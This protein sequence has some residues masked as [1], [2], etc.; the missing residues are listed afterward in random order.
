M[1]DATA[2]LIGAPGAV[3]NIV[4]EVVG[5]FD[6]LAKLET[7]INQLSLAGIDRGMM[8]VLGTKAQKTD[9]PGERENEAA[10]R[11]ILDISDDPRTP[12][13]AF[14]SDGSWS[15]ARGMATA[16]P[17]VIG[18]F[19]GAWA[20]AASGSALLLL[21]GI[22]H[23][24]PPASDMRPYRTSRT[25]RFGVIPSAEGMSVRAN[26]SH[27]LTIAAVLFL[28]KDGS[29]FFAGSRSVSVEETILGRRFWPTSSFSILFL[30]EVRRSARRKRHAVSDV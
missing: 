12:T 29:L 17:L 5:V 11:S 22:F 7:A 19:G 27:S 8:S 15:E 16:V 21:R 1:N 9:Q 4:R 30:P 24:V 10:S 6:T 23:S 13:T 28:M 20:V 25:P 3:P 2:S 26:A 18:G 14:V